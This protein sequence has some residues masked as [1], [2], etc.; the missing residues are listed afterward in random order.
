MPPIIRTASAVTAL[1]QERTRV[2]VAAEE[3]TATTEE[4]TAPEPAI[5]QGEM[6]EAGTVVEAADRGVEVVVAVAATS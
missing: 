2:E 6:P 5:V 3:A 1:I 4:V